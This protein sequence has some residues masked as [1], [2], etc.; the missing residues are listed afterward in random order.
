[1]RKLLPPAC[2]TSASKANGSLLRGS[3]PSPRVAT[4]TTC[5]PC[6]L[7]PLR[8]TPAVTESTPEGTPVGDD[9]VPAPDDSDTSLVRGDMSDSASVPRVWLSRRVERAAT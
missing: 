5:R 7:P 1:M 4:P 2:G 6:A 3:P 8:G 9:V